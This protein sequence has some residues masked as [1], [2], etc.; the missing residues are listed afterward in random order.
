MRILVGALM[1]NLICAVALLAGPAED[2]RMADP[3]GV[4]YAVER[5]ALEA[6]R[7]KAELWQTD[8]CQ[9][10]C[11][12]ALDDRLSAVYLRYK[13]MDLNP[14][15]GVY[16]FSEL[17]AVLDEI[18]AAGKSA[19]LIVMAGSYTPP[20]LFQAGAGHLQTRYRQVSDL[21]QD[22]V[23]LP[24]DPLFVSAHGRM[25]AALAE[26]LRQSPSRLNTLVLV[27]TGGLV[28][29][30]GEI[31]LMPPKAFMSKREKDEPGRDD[32][33]RADLCAD[34]AQA[35]YSE[36][37]V[38][39]AAREMN[40]QVA[41]AF[42]GQYL[43][44]AFVAGSKRF[45]TVKV[46]RCTYPQKNATLNL[47]IK[48]MVRDYGARA[49]LN[50]TVLTGEI[51]DPPILD[52]VRKHGGKI[53]FQV[54]AQQVG[55]RKPRAPCNPAEFDAAMEAGIAAGATYIEVHDGNIH[56]YR[57][58]LPVFDKALKAR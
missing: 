22:L 8:D 26:Y 29:H 54:N 27:K 10:P 34:W 3:R 30:S 17:G 31:R 21:S 58:R 40:A 9:P 15:D 50:S 18:H 1:L 7:R 53:A 46:G 39:A 28:T 55:C 57:D 32:R 42:P 13:W 12:I 47:I 52:W 4:H 37:K 6:D 49:I 38:R 25:I 33:F 45:P 16:D 43:G 41:R 36:D 11:T 20:W 23:P 5:N 44:L 2:W 56:H 24:W 19:S 14:Q 51:G 48:D 35:G